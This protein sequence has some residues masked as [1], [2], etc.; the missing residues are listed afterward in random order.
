[1]VVLSTFLDE[2]AT[3]L[4]QQWR[5][6]GHRVLAVDVLPDLLLH[7][8]SPSVRTAHRIIQMERADRIHELRRA[9]IEALRWSAGVEVELAAHGRSHGGRR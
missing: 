4:A 2:E 9:G 3:R 8:A 1:M 6:A 5:H 7:A